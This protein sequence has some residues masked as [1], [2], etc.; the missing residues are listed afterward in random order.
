M[1]FALLD[2]IARL[3][4]RSPGR[5]APAVAPLL[6]RPWFSAR[7]S[8]RDP[9]GRRGTPDG[10]GEEEV[11]DVHR[12]DREPH[13][14]AHPQPH[15]RRRAARAV[16]VVAVGQDDHDGEDE[17]LEEGPQHVLRWQE[18]VEV[19]VVGARRLAVRLGGDRAGG[20]VAGEQPS[21]YSGITAMKPAMIRVVTRNG[22]DGTPITSRAS[23]SSLI[24]MAPICAVNPQ[25]T[26]ADGA[27]P[28]TR[29]AISRVLKYAERKPVNA[30]VPSWSRAA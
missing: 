5:V 24:R 26:V 4:T 30:D 16:A 17:D 19:V 18:E 9:H 1:T 11:D 21:T 13:R 7:R 22:R 12:D 20:E 14:A 6:A 10:Q 25:P 27:S 29:G 23:I 15:A 2:V 3:P 8:P 28:A